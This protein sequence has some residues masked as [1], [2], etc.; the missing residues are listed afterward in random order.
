MPPKIL[1]FDLGNVLLYFSHERMCRQMADV[2]GISAEAVWRALFDSGLELRYETGEVTP[3]QFY[4]EFCRLTER[5]PPYEALERAASEIFALNVPLAALVAQLRAAGY[6]LGLLSNTNESH[7]E[8]FA[9]GRYGLI[10]GTFHVLAY[11]CRLHAAKPDAKIYLAA[12][13]LA[14]V[15]PTEMFFVD[16]VAGHV[17]GAKSVGVD[18]VQYTTTARL[19]ADLRA[20]GLRFNY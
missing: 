7:I 12:A 4:E 17:A 2:A 5:R 11:S 6:K 3:R 10:P 18:A 20:R 13:E 19:A 15:E 9:S 1:Y 8:Y 16:D 14:G